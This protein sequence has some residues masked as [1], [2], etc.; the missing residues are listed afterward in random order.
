MVEVQNELF[1]ACIVYIQQPDLV[2]DP[3]AQKALVVQEVCSIS[4]YRDRI[5]GRSGNRFMNIK[6]ML[7]GLIIASLFGP[8]RLPF[9]AVKQN[10]LR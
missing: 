5:R 4:Q 9:F 8:S 6:A 2:F 3:I 1:L 7:D 10:V